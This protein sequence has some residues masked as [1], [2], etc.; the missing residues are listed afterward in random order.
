MKRQPHVVLEFWPVGVTRTGSKDDL[1]TGE[2]WQM[3]RRGALV[4]P[5]PPGQAANVPEVGP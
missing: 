3:M 5:L 1:T 4:H 2:D